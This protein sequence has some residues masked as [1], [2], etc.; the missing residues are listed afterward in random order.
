MSHFF[1]FSLR[2][3]VVIRK[4]H[5][6]SIDSFMIGT[7]V[8]KVLNTLNKL[9]YCIYRKLFEKACVRS[10]RIHETFSILF[11]SFDNC[12]INSFYSTGPFLTPLQTLENQIR[13]YW[14]RHLIVDCILVRVTIRL[15]VC[16]WN[17]IQELR[18]KYLLA[19]KIIFL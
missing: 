4:H 10:V 16:V 15:A 17:F 18:I 1:M 8:M 19:I 14:K 2:K 12:S 9:T 11:L 6:K 7:P 13:V 3:H 5:D